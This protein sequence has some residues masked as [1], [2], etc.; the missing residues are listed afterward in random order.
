VFDP[1]PPV[2]PQGTKIEIIL[3]GV[4]FVNQILTSDFGEGPPIEGD[5]P[6]KTDFCTCWSR[7]EPILASFRSLRQLSKV[8]VFISSYVTT[9]S[10]VTSFLGS[11]RIAIQVPPQ[12]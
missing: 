11:G 1:V 10:I 8:S 7:F 6:D 3:V 9:T 4:D 5:P 12:V 2:L